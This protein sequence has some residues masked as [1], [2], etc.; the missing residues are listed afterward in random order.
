[1][2]QHALIPAV[3]CP[4]VPC[5]A[6]HTR[7]R[8]HPPDEVQQE[9]IDRRIVS[10]HRGRHAPRA[11][12]HNQLCVDV[13]QAGKQLLQVSGK[14]LQQQGGVGVGG[15]VRVCVWGGGGDDDINSGMRVT[16]RECIVVG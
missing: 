16:L 10:G 9:A 8:A 15:G 5:P 7:P 4:G 2:H 3:P 13:L 6:P 1:M 14:G 12:L 11:R